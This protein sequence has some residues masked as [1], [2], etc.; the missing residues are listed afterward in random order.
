M[1]YK[2][3]LFADIIEVS[4]A[5]YVYAQPHDYYIEYAALKIYKKGGC[6]GVFRDS[7]RTEKMAR[8]HDRMTQGKHKIPIIFVPYYKR[9]PEFLA[10]NLKWRGPDVEYLQLELLT[11]ELARVA[12]INGR[13]GLEFIPVNMITKEMALYAVSDDPNY[14][15]HVPEHLIDDEIIDECERCI[16][17]CHPKCI[18]ILAI[19]IRHRCSVFRRIPGFRKTKELCELVLSIDPNMIDHVPYY[20]RQSEEIK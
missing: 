12:V 19:L 15:L 5:Y 2:E 4:S 6:I 13:A 1:I 16:D 9:T 17:Y 3:R 8:I 14:M 10:D 18:E 11:P 7:V 20:M